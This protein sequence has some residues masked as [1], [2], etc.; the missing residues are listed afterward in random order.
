MNTLCWIVGAPG[1]GKTTIARQ[2]L[3]P[4]SYLIP[5]PKWTVG[6]GVVAAGHYSGQTFDGADMV[7][8]NGAK[9]ALAYWAAHLK[10]TKL[11]LFDGDRFS[12]AGAV[13]YL[14][15][16]APDS[17]FMV[18]LV[19]AEQATLDAR[20]AARGSNQDPVWMKGRV[21]KA[22][23]FAALP[24]WNASHT[25]S[26]DLPPEEVAKQVRDLLAIRA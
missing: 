17:H 20:R 5:K 22:H 25:V 26:S 10:N 14:R 11:T 3:D 1:V 7:P 9:E 13:E 16:A 2:L 18:V 4:D 12:N 6:E 19:L 23:N 24:S 21:T 8:Y 15:A